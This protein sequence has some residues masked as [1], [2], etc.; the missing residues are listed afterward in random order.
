MRLG[1]E[2]IPGVVR[3]RIQGAFADVRQAECLVS[4][5]GMAQV[6]PDRV[7]HDGGG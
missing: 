3:M 4:D 7:I 1:E 5:H 2:R 6:P